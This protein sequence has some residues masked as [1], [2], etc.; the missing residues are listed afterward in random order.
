MAFIHVHYIIAC[1]C[2]LHLAV[3][4]LCVDI[5]LFIACMC[6]NATRRKYNVHLAT[7]LR[8]Y[9]VSYLYGFT[10]AVFRIFVAV[11]WYNCNQLYVC[12]CTGY[13]SPVPCSCVYVWIYSGQEDICCSCT[14]HI[15]HYISS[16]YWWCC[17]FLRKFT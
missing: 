12:F 11:Y 15:V 17:V 8:F 9:I 1:K 10:F 16:K 3:F 13:V 4:A 7:I 5:V 2:R 14:T 6:I